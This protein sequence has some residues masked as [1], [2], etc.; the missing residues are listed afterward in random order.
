MPIKNLTDRDSLRPQLARL[1]KLRKGGEK[2]G[3]KPGDDLPYFRP[4]MNDPDVQRA[5]V[6]AYGEQ[7][8]MVNVILF[9]ETLEDNF[10]TWIEC[11]DA[12]GLVF[13]SDGE[14]WRVWRDG[15]SYKRGEK[16]HIDKEGQDIV[17]RL[18]F[19]VPE[20]IQQ[21]YVGTVTLET[22][23]NHDL[24][25]I[26]A[27]L[28]AAEQERGTLRG[29]QFVLRRVEEEISV[30]GWGDRK[31]KR[32]KATKHLVKIEPPRQLFTAM[33][34]GRA[35]TPALESKADEGTGEIVE[36][37]VVE[38]EQTPEPET[39]DDEGDLYLHA[40]D[41]SDL[42]DPCPWKLFWKLA[43]DHLGYNHKNHVMSAWRKI[44]GNPA[45]PVEDKHGNVPAPIEMW[46]QLRDH[47]E[48]KTA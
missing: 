41:P 16:P 9:Y 6:E 38:Q 39:G 46:L 29:A 23:S 1:G 30:P 42:P 31:G 17:G 45:A 18:E 20:L 5:F 12:S 2:T 47:Q 10:S 11:W 27:V 3:N 43:V 40:Y 25:N 8:K 48:A 15:S 14:F 26:G 44:V 28:L 36:A 19:L 32:S 35:N 21:G 33:I 13:R 24:R 34:E 4:D 37:E 7:P 22:H